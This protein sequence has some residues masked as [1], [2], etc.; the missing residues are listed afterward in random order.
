MMVYFGLLGAWATASAWLRTR[1][2]FAKWRISRQL[3]IV[4][5]SSRNFLATLIPPHVYALTG[6]SGPGRGQGE[7]VV[8]HLPQTVVLFLSARSQCSQI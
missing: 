6:P 4:S 1:K 8:H 3:I 5:D 2:A 7:L